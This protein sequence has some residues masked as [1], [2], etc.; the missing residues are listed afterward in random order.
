MEFSVLNTGV[1]RPNPLA[2]SLLNKSTER[3][4][5]NQASFISTSGCDITQGARV[6][7]L[8]EVPLTMLA[9][10]FND[11]AGQNSSGDVTNTFKIMVS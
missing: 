2:T 4:Q 5:L 1:Y 7:L 8:Y 9:T 11:N 6:N 3:F 10:R